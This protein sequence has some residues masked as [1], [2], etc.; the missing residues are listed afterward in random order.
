LFLGIISSVII[1][2]GWRY[3]T[4]QVK[5]DDD[6]YLCSIICLE[7]QLYKKNNSNGSNNA[8]FV[9][10][11]SRIKEFEKRFGFVPQLNE[12]EKKLYEN[13]SH[14]E[15]YEVFKSIGELKKYTTTEE[16]KK[17]DNVLF[18]S[19]LILCLVSFVLIQFFFLWA[20]LLAVTAIL[21][22]IKINELKSY[23]ELTD[24]DIAEI[25]KIIRKCQKPETEKN[26][27]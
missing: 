10:T 13:F 7:D 27:E 17:I 9:T 16:K 22:V 20:V 3:I 18:Y 19:F 5:S 23:M 25:E 14:I 4:H 11:D 2:T 24:D 6:A 21:A 12:S 26:S 15:K 8:I 1:L